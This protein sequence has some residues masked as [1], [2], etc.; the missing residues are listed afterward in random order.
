MCGHV[1][2]AGKLVTKDEKMMD[3]LL[4]LDYFRGPDATGFFSVNGNTRGIQVSKIASGPWDLWEQPKYK[5]ARVGYSSSVFAG[6]N[7]LA[8]KG[9]K[10]SAFNAHPYQYENIVG[11][12]NGTLSDTTWRR[13]EEAIDEKFPVDSM[14]L[15]NSID[16]LGIDKT[17]EM[18]R[19]AG[20]EK[21]TCPDAYALVWYNQEE[22]T[23]NFLRNKE[24]P[25]W[26][27][28]DKDFDRIIWSSEWPFIR[29]AHEM[30]APGW[31][32]YVDE[33]G[34]RFFPFEE[35]VHYKFDMDK[36]RKG[37]WKERPKPVVKVIK[38]KEPLPVATYQGGYS[39][40]RAT[41][42]TDQSTKVG[43]TSVSK[44]IGATTTGVTTAKAAPSEKDNIIQLFGDAK[45][46]LG[47]II[48]QE[49]FADISSSG[50]AYCSCT[51]FYDDPGITIYDRDD[52]VL[53]ADCSPHIGTQ[54]GSRIYLS[55][56]EGLK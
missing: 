53:C 45:S 27:A 25:L 35:D 46:P 37:D 28:F 9:N 2:M 49:R 52:I 10:G 42:G 43:G 8:T 14:A 39:P 36:L 51:V 24:R 3:R 1:G 23:L 32:L 33:G 38:G 22:N 47:G 29:H 48:T 56:L 4:F 50:C 12:H 17:I 55:N 26:Y 18:M 6:H 7:R 15:I 16:K 41:S 11:A 40:F 34:F 19:E 30:T 44:M 21:A 5:A 54:K 20:D 13:I 31:G